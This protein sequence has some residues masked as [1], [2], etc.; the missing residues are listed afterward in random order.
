M[1]VRSWLTT[2][3]F[4]SLK[5]ETGFP[6]CEGIT[7]S[8]ALSWTSL[9]SYCLS[10]ELSCVQFEATFTPNGWADPM[11]PG[12]TFCCPTTAGTAQPISRSVELTN[13]AETELFMAQQ[14]GLA[15]VCRGGRDQIPEMAQ[16]GRVSSLLLAEICLNTWQNPTSTSHKHKAKCTEAH[17]QIFLPF[18]FRIKLI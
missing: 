4:S 7:W 17:K 3:S 2:N 18:H 9:K 15:R 16:W 11:H 12:T 13:P 5:P 14:T 10:P 6:F 8:K 1:P